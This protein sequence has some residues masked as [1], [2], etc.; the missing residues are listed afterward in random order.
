[1]NVTELKVKNLHKTA[2]WLHDMNAQD[3]HFVA[4]LASDPNEIFEQIWTLTQFQEPLAYVAWND[5]GDMI[6]FLG[7]LPFF[8]QNL[9]R[10]LGPFALEDEEAVIEQLWDKASLTIQLHFKAVKVA[11]FEA[12]HALV[13]F[14]ERHNFSLYNVEKTLAL[15]KEHYSP[16][17]EG[18]PAIVPLQPEDLPRLKELHPEGAYYS[19]D[20]IM[21]YSQQA[22][23]NLWGY[24]QNGELMGYVYFETILAEEEGEICFVNV[25]KAHR[26]KGIGSKL[27]EHALQY[28]MEIHKLEVVTISVRTLNE[29]AEQLYKQLGFIE[30]NK[31]FAYEK[32]WDRPGSSF[33]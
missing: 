5:E 26:G 3:K 29:Q 20:E 27:I 4:W 18:S 13:A 33:H 14:T 7:I 12:N 2:Q 16:S 11:C 22:A 9:C 23:N 15:H 6:G 8:E 10:L 17:H 1:M 24:Q 19:A 32:V 30:V 21:N 25:A 28:A 31:I